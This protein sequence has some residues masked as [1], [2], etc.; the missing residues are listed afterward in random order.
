A[1]LRQ[2]T[3]RRGDT[4][5]SDERRAFA[6]WVSHAIAPR[7]I[8]GLA[9]PERRNLYSVDFEVLV[10]RHALLGMSRDQVIAALPALRGMG[11]EPSLAGQAALSSG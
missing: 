1:R 4:G 6:E 3:R 2:I 8:A 9:N 11:P 10:D 5:G 7:N